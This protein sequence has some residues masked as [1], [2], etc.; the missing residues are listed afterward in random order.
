MRIIDPLPTTDLFD[1][2]FLD[3]AARLIRDNPAGLTDRHLR[4]T[5]VYDRD[6]AQRG[7]ER[8]AAALQRRAARAT[9]HPTAW[10][11]TETEM[12]DAIAKAIEMATA[13]LLA[14]I[15]KLEARDHADLRREIAELRAAFRD[16]LGNCQHYEGIFRRGTIYSA[17]SV[18]THRGSLWLTR[19]MTSAVPGD[20]DATSRAWVLVQKRSQ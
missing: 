13:P 14:R 17:G 9:G 16:H 6:L 11:A 7:A 19:E 1:V 18:T 15:Q 20:A 4:A 3:E 8:R 5:A 12:A 10:T 2:S